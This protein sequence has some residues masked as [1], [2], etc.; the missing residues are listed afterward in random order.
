MRRMAIATEHDAA[1]LAAVEAKDPKGL[2]AA[3][4]AGANPSAIKPGGHAALH[5][6]LQ[7][8][9]KTMA[10]ALLDAGA[11]AKVTDKK[12]A[13]ALHLV[14]TTFP[15]LDIAALLL[16]RGADVNACGGSDGRAPLHDAVLR[17][18]LE[19]AGFLL[20]HGAS[21]DVRDAENGL[22]PLQL[23]IK[24]ATKTSF[25]AARWLLERGADVN[26]LD[27]YGDNALNTAAKWTNDLPIITELF[28]RGTALVANKYGSTALHHAVSTTHG[29]ATAIWDLLLAKGCDVN[30]RNRSGRT[31]LFEAASC[32]NPFCVKYLLKKG[33]DA[34]LKDE[35]GE[36]VL[37]R[38]KAL[39]QTEIISILEGATK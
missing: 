28:E 31:P 1:L 33:A 35:K 37:D 8:K 18:K 20:E 10:K 5:M 26:A 14:A 39:K 22:T 11:D 38:A 7:W 25:A 4:A 30:A 3:L 19:L 17:P 2:K 15:D 12:G 16:K 29:R 24:E 23:T 9:S 6:A 34:S 36:T 21:I 13:T 32:W 27:G